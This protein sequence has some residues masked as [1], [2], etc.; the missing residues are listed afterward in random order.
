MGSLINSYQSPANLIIPGLWLGN[1][2]A[3]QDKLFIEG[4]NIG[5]I[6]N[7]TKNIPFITIP[8][9]SLHLYRVPVDD[10]LQLDEIRNME[11]WS[12]EIVVKLMN[13]YNN[14]GNRSILV[15][16]HAGMQR[17]AAVVAMFLIAKYRCSPNEAI[18][19]IRSKRSIAFMP[20]TNF[21]DSI[22]GF[23]KLFQKN[24]IESNN[25]DLQRKIPFPTDMVSGR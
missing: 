11:L 15:H 12:P 22:Q 21:N 8:G 6:F 16:C 1:I 24:L 3:S 20:G 2:Q 5:T 14:R 25:P 17:S 9:R 19:Y 18:Q 4:N 7:C 23:A 13:E 10:N